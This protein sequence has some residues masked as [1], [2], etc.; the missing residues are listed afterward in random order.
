MQAL[1]NLPIGKL[2][3]PG[4]SGMSWVLRVATANLVSMSWLRSR[5]TIVQPRPFNAAD[6]LK[7]AT[8]L[9]AD[10]SELHARLPV[11]GRVDGIPAILYFGKTVGADRKLSQFCG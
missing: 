9:A 3:A 2:P 4:E 5:L 7:L 11:Y 10:P 6:S 1:P 8:V